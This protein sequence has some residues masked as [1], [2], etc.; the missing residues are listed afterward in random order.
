MKRHY[1]Q[2]LKSQKNIKFKRLDAKV[3]NFQSGQMM[4]ITHQKSLILMS[5]LGN[6]LID[7]FL[8]LFLFF[9]F[10]LHWVFIALHWLLSW[11]A[12]LYLLSMG[13]LRTGFLSTAWA[14]GAEGFSCRVHRHICP[15]VCG[16]LPDQR[17]NVSLH[18]QEI[19]NQ[20]TTGEVLDFT[21][22]SFRGKYT[23]VIRNV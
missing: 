1:F 9:S 18:Q 4:T 21:Y 16:V 5:L 12:T 22:I 10:W 13:F 7:F 6:I 8:S 11:G 3:S 23:S 20:S 2:F 15:T 19:L 14:L 17:L